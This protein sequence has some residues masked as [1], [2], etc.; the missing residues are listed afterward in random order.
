MNIRKAAIHEADLVSDLC[1]RSKAYWGYSEEF[2]EA[3]REDLTISAND[4]ETSLVYVIEEDSGIKGFMGLER[5]EDRILLGYFFIDPDAIGKG[6]GKALWEHMIQVVKSLNERAVLIHSD[7]Y[8]EE[9][10]LARGAVRI[11]EIESTIIPGRKLPLL[12]FEIRD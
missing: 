3:C 6:Y 4:I 9:F 1:F 2:M 10:Y 5:S 8:A 12:H 11:G 7:P